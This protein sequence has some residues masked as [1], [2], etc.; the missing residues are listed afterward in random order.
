MHVQDLYFSVA[1]KLLVTDNNNN[2]SSSIKI[3]NVMQLA[4]HCHLRSLVTAIVLGFNHEAY[5][6]LQPTKLQQKRISLSRRLSY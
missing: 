3:H 5:N 1:C 4:M 6:A 2:S